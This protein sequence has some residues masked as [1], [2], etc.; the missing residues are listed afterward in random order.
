MSVN[1]GL[2]KGRHDMPCEKYIFEEIDTKDIF[3][4]AYQEKVINDFLAG[5]T[6]V[7]VYVTGLTCVTATLVACC[8]KQGITLVLMHYDRASKQ[9]ISQTF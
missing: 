3:N 5:K 1:Y 9:Y 7:T 2:I 4:F 8:L 6:S